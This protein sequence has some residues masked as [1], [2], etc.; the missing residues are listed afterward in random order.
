VNNYVSRTE[1]LRTT[2]KLL[3]STI[4][5]YGAASKQTVSRWIKLSMQKAGVHDCF[6]PHSTRAASSS[7]AHQ[8]G[9]SLETIAKSAGWTGARTFAK[10]YNK[11]LSKGDTMPKAIQSCLKWWQ[12]Y[13]F[14]QK[15]WNPNPKRI[16]K[17][18]FVFE[19]VHLRKTNLEILL[20]IDIIE[21]PYDL[22]QLYQ[23]TK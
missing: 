9:L 3:I 6:K 10:Y 4:N 5:P 12:Y 8:R 22:K 14:K 19:C 2:K 16:I 23:S 7:M 15:M 13:Q 18:I 1:K 21:I 17:V 20:N 11:P